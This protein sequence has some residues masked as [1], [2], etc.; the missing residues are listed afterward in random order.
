MKCVICKHGQTVAGT[1]TVTFER[2]DS[3]VV[4]KKVPSQICENCGEAYI[5]G[6]ISTELIAEADRI[7]RNGAEVDVRNYRQAAA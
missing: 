3:T 4:F 1:S 5:D 6:E 7:I 2:G